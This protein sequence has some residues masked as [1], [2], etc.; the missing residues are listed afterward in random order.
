MHNK[1]YKMRYKKYKQLYQIYKASD[2]RN[3]DCHHRFYKILLF[4]DKLFM[5]FFVY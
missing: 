5:F 1:K 4:F 2:V 3:K